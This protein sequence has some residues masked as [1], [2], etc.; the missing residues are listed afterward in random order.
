MELKEDSLEERLLHTY[1][2][3][4]TSMQMIYKLLLNALR[5]RDFRTFRNIVEYNLTKQP[6]AINVNHVL[7]DHCDETCL[8]IASRNGLTKFVEYLL[9]KGAK[10]NMV[11]EAHTRAPIHFATEGG[12]VDT[13]AALLAEP[14][15]NPNLEAGQQTAL[16]IAVRRK[17]SVGRACA[18]LLLERGASASIPNS[19]GQTALHVAAMRGQRDMVEL[20][21]EKCR[22]CPDL[23]SYRDYN[24]RT[25]REVIQQR[26][27][28]VQLP[29]NCENRDMNAHDLKYYLLAN[30]EINFT[31]SL[32]TVKPE[33]VRGVVEDLLEMAAQRD[34]RQA[35]TGLLSK[36]QQGAFSV[37]K[38][39]RAAVQ[40]GH[41]S[42][43][44][45]LLN[46]EPEAAND[47]VLDAC[48]ELGMTGKR[49]DDTSNQLECLRLILEQENIDVRC[50]DSK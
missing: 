18:G 41:H 26:L 23:D 49:A 19:K 3:S 34:L 15:I 46:V 38:A 47:L 39:A 27:P 9:S 33:V 1:D 24:G 20:I 17:D 4:S 13:L 32:E 50:T 42:I 12:H 28:D 44:R 43:L 29:P 8:D 37:K 36:L 48:L 21:L 6:S 31:R 35:V 7:P 16:H 22:Q 5:S 10:P 45:E 11:N 40:Q 2:S 14:T 25:A 30:D